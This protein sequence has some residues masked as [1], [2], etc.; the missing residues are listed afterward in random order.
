MRLKST[1][2]GLVCFCRVS[3]GVL[4]DEPVRLGATPYVLHFKVVEWS[5]Y[6][7]DEKTGLKYRIGLAEKHMK[8]VPN[9]TALGAILEITNT[10]HADVSL[11]AYAVSQLVS[12]LYVDNE[13]VATCPLVGDAV[14]EPILLK[15]GESWVQLFGF[16]MLGNEPEPGEREVVVAFG[17]EDPEASDPV[18]LK[19]AT[20]SVEFKQETN[21]KPE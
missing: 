15:P 18:E 1:I 3:L 4:A 13:R 16:L 10:G 6:K 20:V 11:H 7:T 14:E 9:N 19:S 21:N 12:W 17:V 5:E 2:V 8:I